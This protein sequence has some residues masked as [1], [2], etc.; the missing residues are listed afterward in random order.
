MGRRIASVLLVFLGTLLPL[1]GLLADTGLITT[2]AGPGTLTAP[3]GLSL[4]AT[5]N[6]FVADSGNSQVWRIDAVTGALTAIAGN[7]TQGFGG[8]GGP[9]TQASLNGPTATTVDAVGNV[10]ISDSHNSRVRRVDTVSGIITTVAGNGVATSS[11]DGGP[12]AAASLIF[13]SGLSFDASGNLYIADQ[14]GGRIRRVDANTGII[15]TVVG[16]GVA[17]FA[18]DGGPATSAELYIPVMTIFDAAGNMYIADGFNCRIRRVDASTGFI[19]TIAGTGSSSFTGDGG[20]ALSTGIGTPSAVALDSS[21]NLFVV[22]NEAN[23][24]LRIDSAT[25]TVVTVAGNG[26]QGF[27]GLGVYSAGGSYSQTPAFSGDGGLATS[28]QLSG[29]L[30]VVATPNGNILLSDTNN[31]RIRRVALPSPYIYTASTLVTNVNGPTVTLNASVAPIGGTGTPT[32]SVQFFDAFYTLL[33]SV[34]L[35]NGAASLSLSTLSLGSHSITASYSGDG[36]FSSSTSMP[37]PL[38]VRPF[39]AA[40]SLSANGS[41]IVNQTN[42]YSIR[43]SASGSTPSVP[44]GIVQLLDGGTL[45]GSGTLNTGAAQISAAFSTIGTHSLTAA[46]LGD[47]NFNAGSSA[48]LL[49]PILQDPGLSVTSSANPAV[50][51][52]VVTLTATVAA[53]ATGSVQFR[54]SPSPSGNAVTLGTATVTNGVA[55]WPATFY[56]AGTHYVTALYIGDAN[57]G[58]ELSSAIVQTIN[59][60]GTATT[61]SSTQNPTTPNQ[62]INIIAQVAPAPSLAFSLTPSGAVQ[63]LDGSAVLA[64][65]PLTNGSATFNVSFAA[66]GSHSLTATYNGDSYFSGSNSAALLQSVKS[67]S[68]LVFA[69]DTN[70]SLAGS[71]INLSATLYQSAATGT[72]QFVDLSVPANPVTLGTVALAGSK[73]SLS[74]SS[75]SAG[76]HSLTAN[77]SGDANFASAAS[78]ILAQVVK[79][80]TTTGLVADVPSPIYGQTIHFTASVSP[81]SASGT[82]QFLDGAT[83]LGAISLSGGIAV[84]T[85]GTLQTGTHSITAVYSGDGSNGSST[86]AVLTPAV[87]KAST[88][89]TVASSGSPV[90]A[91]TSVTFSAIVS[92]ASA[93][94]SVQFF[95]GAAS[96]GIATLSQGAASLTTAALAPGNHSITASY[97]GDANFSA[98]TSAALPQLV[99]GTSTIAVTSNASQ[100]MFGQAIQFT[101]SV[102]PAA[103]TGS[104]QF[105]DGSAILGSVSVSAGAAVLTVPGLAVGSHTITASYGGDSIYSGGTSAGLTETVSKANATATATSSANPALTGAPV[106]FTAAVSPASATGTVQFKDGATVLS[107]VTLG[108]GAASFTT[109]ALVAG[110]HS[111]TAAY[112]GDGNY[113]G[114]VSAAVNETVNAPAP[115]AP[116]NL[117]ATAVSSSQI[118]LTWT[119]SATS[120]VTYN[121]YSATASGFTPSASNRIATGVTST[122]YSNTGLSPA[123]VHYYLVTAQNSG[124]ESAASNQAV[125]TTQAAGASCQV[126]YSV[127]T[128]WNVGF[129][130]AISIVNSGTQPINGWTLTWTWA[131]NQAINQA[132]NANYTQSG[133]KATLTNASWNGTIAAGA[134]VSGMGFNASYSGTNTAPSAFYL[135]GQ[136][137]H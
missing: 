64:T 132:W 18:G 8:D 67:P 102:A 111:I 28:A 93:T 14:T 72:I 98:N 6:L 92:P 60:F 136:L 82:V 73:A 115:G 62:N 121:V 126:S 70:P 51:G 42:S 4:D 103:A 77:Y 95:D 123:T 137:C 79:T 19:T 29:P 91:G 9:A 118:N 2:I 50:L 109:S 53:S 20:L 97:G 59:L 31:S 39:N 106:T 10:F 87:G 78:S 116:S 45:L 52:A 75:L 94:G 129:G 105:L 83:P 57:F 37:G 21:G 101:A 86:S 13:P 134:T 128:Q 76:T 58:T 26:D 66:T 110:S 113:A 85:T 124:G 89:V 107:T 35:T 11:G 84:L 16:N 125:A 104:V 88:G 17:G 7:G 38:S 54:D 12:A 119:A 74:I 96:L 112:S 131:G 130:T 68:S 100:V 32:G 108:S 114:A 49:Q 24:I 56:S 69:S 47:I 81:A 80:T 46:Y 48:A 99:K 55:S 40:V 36:T 44:T 122:S 71:V 117:T 90:L 23:R 63:L 133:A 33:G 3:A 30:W 41:A 43:V 65:V 127:T 22:S 135:N 61:I 34:P 27:S 25:S 5:G 1:S 120:G 15:T